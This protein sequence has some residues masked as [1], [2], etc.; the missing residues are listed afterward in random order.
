MSGTLRVELASGKSVVHT[1]RADAPLKL[2]LPN[3]H[4]DAAWVFLATLGGGLVGG[5]VIALDVEVGAGAA[6][7]IGSQSSTKVFRS[8]RETSQ[9]LRADVGDDAALVIAPDPV[10]PFAGSRYAQSTEV[11]LGARSTLVLADIATCGRASR[12][13]RWDFERYTSRMK[14]ARGGRLV[15]LDALLLDRAHGDLRARLHRF[16]ALATIVA[17][18][19]RASDVRAS[20]LATASTSETDA[21]LFGFTRSLGDDVTFARLAT[22][23]V[24]LAIKAV[25]SHVASIAAILGEDPFARRW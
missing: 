22:T 12:G 19:P 3:N 16:E 2:L 24:E 23:R 9:T 10:A 18:G 15:A 5:D 25:R 8:K 21:P 4:G 11:T 7:F 20:L 6:A 17:V 1:A 14:V 13:E